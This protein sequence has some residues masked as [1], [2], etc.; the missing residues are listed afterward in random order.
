MYQKHLEEL[1]NVNCWASSPEFP[2]QEVWSRAGE[3][4]FLASCQMILMLFAWDHTLRTTDLYHGASDSSFV[5][6][7]ALF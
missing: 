4:A 2:I 6:L 5:P 1:L 3:A 7:I